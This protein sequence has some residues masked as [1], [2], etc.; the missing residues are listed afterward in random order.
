[1]EKS[2]EIYLFHQG[3]YYHAYN[4][5]G[6]HPEN[7][8]AWF[9]VW[10]PNAKAISVVGDF[11]SWNGESN[12]LVRIKDSSVW[13]VFVP[14]VKQFDNYKYQILT[15]D[16]KTLYKAD[17]YAFHSE[18][19]GATAS[20]VYDLTD[21]DWTDAEYLENR[22]K[23][24]HFEKPMNVYEVNFSSWKKHD[25]GSNYSYRKLADTLVPYVVDM[26]YTHIECMPL[27]EYPYE[28]SWGYQ[29]TGYFSVTSRFGTPD[30]FRYFVNKCHE[31]GI[32]VILDWVPAHFPKDEHGLIEW[33][34]ECLYENQGWDR[35]EFK[36]WGTR[37]FDYGRTEVQSFLIS[38]ANF[39]IKKYHID[40]LRVDA[41]AS[42]LYLDYGKEA[43]EWIPN[44]NGENK[45]IE[46]IAFLQKLNS[47]ILT[48]NPTALMIAEES[49]AW[50]MVTKPG[51]I[52]GL[53]FNYK[54]NIGWMNDT[55]SY[56]ELDP[57]F[58]KDNHNKLTFS[59]FYAFSENFVLPIS[60]DEV[61]Y[62]KKSLLNKMHGE[63]NQKFDLMRAFLMYMY[64][65]PGK[66]LSFMGSEFAQFDEWN[67]AKGIDFVLLEYE[68]HNKMHS[69]TKELNHV[70]KDN[71]ELYE[72][73]YSWEGFRWLTPDD[74]ENNVIAFERKNKKGESLICVANF[75]PV[76]HEHYR[77]GLDAG[78]YEEILSSNSSKFGGNGRHYGTIES[79]AVRINGFDNS[80][81]LTLEP[82]SAVY[83]KKIDT[84][85]TT[86]SKFNSLE[87]EQG[88]R[89]VSTIEAKNV[90]SKI[91]ESKTAGKNLF[92]EDDM[93]EKFVPKQLSSQIEQKQINNTFSDEKESLETELN[94]TNNSE[95]KAKRGR[96][97]KPIDPELANKPKLPRGRPRKPIDPELANK[98][99]L[100]RGR[101]RKPIDPELAN[102]PKLPRGRPRKPIDP[103]LA[104]KP[105]LPRGR[106]R[107]HT[108]NN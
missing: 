17:P 98:P 10:A 3:T 2:K 68:K 89:S 13:E 94:Q 80:I 88:H 60:H 76:R 67:N 92:T 70:Y 90:V 19:N 64:A 31:N 103:E 63:Y 102:K 44:E 24:N 26:G 107:K 7:G 105:K 79:Y 32:G 62:G 101:P 33:D 100:P 22:K 83:F 34:G 35:I 36:E 95:T 106:P 48:E 51:Y 53:G 72:I 71:S 9:R 12:K 49:T 45:N 61:V 66:K 81:E 46:A 38:S 11:N 41:V 82:N 75:S 57:F 87:E 54:W 29:V 74:H 65:H 50:P 43:G 39:F 1:M 96:P 91:I 15:K 40:G 47:V 6:C 77:V 21:Y 18:T 30:D 93:N 104:N 20:K 4:L 69:F 99:K 14:V 86:S 23:E 73:D 16:N 28:G 37:R 8:G 78:R 42:M 55:L 27:T 97:R 5:L 25:D 59:M 85:Q 56:V 52:G 108:E 84:S 58:R